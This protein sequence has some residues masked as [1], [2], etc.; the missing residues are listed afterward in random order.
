MGLSHTDC[1]VVLPT[2]GLGLTPRQITGSLLSHMASVHRINSVKVS[3][4]LAHYQATSENLHCTQVS[5]HHS[6]FI[7]WICT[8]TWAC[9]FSIPL[10][11]LQVWQPLF[12]QQTDCYPATFNASSSL[13]QD[14]LEKVC[15]PGQFH[16]VSIRLLQGVVQVQLQQMDQTSHFFLL[17]LHLCWG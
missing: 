9:S 10:W 4:Q 17:K 8:R 12:V 2:R 6:C 3:S 16:H 15:P 7:I 5:G 1:C 11:G 14:N 13:I